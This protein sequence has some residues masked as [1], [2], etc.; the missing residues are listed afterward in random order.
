[1]TQIQ[2]QSLPQG[3]PAELVNS[4]VFLLK[5]LGMAGKEWSFER[6]DE[7]GLHP[8]HH[9][10]LAVLDEGA[11]ET[12][13]A[14]A[15]ALGYDKGQLV[16]LLDELE[17]SGLIERHRDPDD[18]R[19]HVVHMTPAGRKMLERVRRVS[20][21]LDEEFLASLSERERQ[22]LHELLLKVAEW[23]LPGCSA[24]ARTA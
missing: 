14:I 1:V 23:H 21:R 6:Y 9:A 10:I 17:E 12:P 4:T 16:G 24:K 8:Y 5:R 18:R 2:P 20:R 15:D 11:A 3:Y 13:G 22:Q 7:F 19:R